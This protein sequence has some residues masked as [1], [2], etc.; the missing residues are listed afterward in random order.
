MKNNPKL[1]AL[2]QAAGLTAYV[3]LVALFMQS[4]QSWFGSQKDDPILSPMIFLLVFIISA[5]V[6]ASIMLAY[7]AILFFRG[8]RKTAMKI[9][10]QSIGW[11][12]F[13]SGSNIIFHIA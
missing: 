11:L 10:L 6:S 8:K 13:F 9:V 2:A 4:L 7:P 12:V 5:L 3:M 1:V